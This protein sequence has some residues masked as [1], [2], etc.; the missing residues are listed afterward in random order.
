MSWINTHPADWFNTNENQGPKC[1]FVT[2]LGHTECEDTNKLCAWNHDCVDLDNLYY[3]T[4]L[5]NLAFE[6]NFEWETCPEKINLFKKGENGVRGQSLRSY[7]DNDGVTVCT[8]S[9][10]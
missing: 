9:Y 7:T 10:L 6:L 4:N 1:S 2:A 8:Y 3:K 5:T